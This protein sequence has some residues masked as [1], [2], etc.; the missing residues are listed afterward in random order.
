M[1]DI[2]LS[3]LTNSTAVSAGT[4]VFDVL[5]NAVELHIT[6]QYNEGRITGEAYSTV[7]LGSLQAVLAQSIKYLM[8]EQAADKQAELLQEQIESE[9]KN[10]EDGGVIDLT[11]QKLQE[12]ID[13][14]VGKTAESYEAIQSSQSRSNRENQLNARVVTKTEAETA[15]LNKRT[16]EQEAFT[17]RTD[18]ESAQKVAL[19]AAQ[20]L[21]FK[22]DAKQKLLKQMLDGYAATLSI[23]GSAIAPQTVIA[24]S[25]D[26]IANDL[27]VDLDGGDAVLII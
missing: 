19:M 15:L 14:I 2:T 11:K 5:I 1:T 17:T 13:L 8:E 6:D 10:N 26:D 3:Q 12:E 22:T 16:L 4:G 27:L 23:A 25:I 21:G 7:Y 9:N 20:T 18:A 24:D